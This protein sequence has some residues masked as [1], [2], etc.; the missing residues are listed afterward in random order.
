M[1]SVDRRQAEASGM[2]LAII[3]EEI[4]KLKTLDHPAVLRLF[5]YYVDDHSIHLITDVLA[6]GHLLEV[7][8]NKILAGCPPTETWVCEVFEQ[9]CKAIAYCHGKGVMHKDLKLDNMMLDSQEPPQAVVIDVGFAELFPVHEAETHRSTLK[10]GTLSTMA[11]EVIMMNFNYKCDVWS[12]GCCLYGLLC[13]RPTAFRKSD[14]SFEVHPYPFLI[15]EERTPAALQDF[16]HKQQQGPDWSNFIGGANARD[17]ITR[18]LTFDARFRPGMQE[19]LMHAWFHSPFGKHQVLE[20]EQLQSLLSFHHSNA[21]EQAVYLD[22]ASQVPIDQ[23]HDI[24]RIFES[25]DVDGSGRLDAAELAGALRE[26][27]LDPQLAAQAAQNLVQDGGSVEFSTFV[28]ALVQ[29]K[30][31]LFKRH[32]RDAFNRLDTDGSGFITQDELRQLLED[33][34][35]QRVEA[36]Q[37]S[38]NVFASLGNCRLIR[39]EQLL[40]YFNHGHALSL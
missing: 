18:M 16:M 15:P 36:E 24:A 30:R 39:F 1:K 33:G 28:A 27:G 34:H 32:L 11:P 22:V 2:P 13:K 35:L 40:E 25:M 31:S 19:V 6:G 29:S 12:L 10:A 8:K 3:A 7:M 37:A 17:V 38:E 20:H 14:G 23:L 21:L 5:E 9:V 26:A 4:D